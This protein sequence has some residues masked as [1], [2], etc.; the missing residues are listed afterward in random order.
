MIITYI[1]LGIRIDFI[2]DPLW[3]QVESIFIPMLCSGQI[4]KT[5]MHL[6]PIV[7]S[8]IIIGARYRSF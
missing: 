5:C 4:K 1:V 3:G 6:Q 2:L 7:C 8:E